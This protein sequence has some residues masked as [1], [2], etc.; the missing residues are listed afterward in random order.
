MFVLPFALGAALYVINPT[1]MSLLFTDPAGVSMLK[2][3]IGMMLLG[4]FVTRRMI[5]IKV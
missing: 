1:Y 4:L 3:G 5:A 2:G